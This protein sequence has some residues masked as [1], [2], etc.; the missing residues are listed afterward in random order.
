MRLP[1]SH[2]GV[3]GFKP[4]YG[5]LSRHGLIAYARY[6][7][8]YFVDIILMTATVPWTRPGC[9][10]IPLEMLRLSQVRMFQNI[11]LA[12]TFVQMPRP[13]LIRLMLRPLQRSP[14]PSQTQL[15]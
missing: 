6:G 15:T 5:R 13:A 11:K 7:Q 1:A 8:Q 9:W 2:C 3:V 12:I 14:S 10:H 4:T